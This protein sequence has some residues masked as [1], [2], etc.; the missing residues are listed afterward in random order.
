MMLLVTKAVQVTSPPPPLPEPLH[1]LTVT[2][3][4][5][6]SVEP[7]WTSHVTRIV[8]PPPVPASLH[9]VMVAFVV[10]APIIQRPR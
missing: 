8:P 7:G 3:R 2:G 1:W 4:A 6:A 10:L 9:W 5:D